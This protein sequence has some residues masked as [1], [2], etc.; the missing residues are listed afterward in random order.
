MF[1]HPAYGRA[2]Y[3]AFDVN[4]TYHVLGDGDVW[5]YTNADKSMATVVY[6]A[7]LGRQVTS[8]DGYPLVQGA[9]RLGQL[10][11][12]TVSSEKTLEAAAEK[13]K[14]QIAPPKPAEP[15]VPAAVAPLVVPPPMIAPSAPPMIVSAPAPSAADTA[16]NFK[17]Y[18]IGAAVAVALMALR[19]KFAARGA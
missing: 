5:A 9:G 16:P 13:A 11:S 3:G 8:D 19:G 4:L 14:A 1:Q 10:Q 15:V 12:D 18:I 6:S 17:P 7:K 2:S